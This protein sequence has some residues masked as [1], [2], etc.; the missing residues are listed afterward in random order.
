MKNYIYI[1][2]EGG[3]GLSLRVG[4]EKTLVEIIRAMS[5]CGKLDV[6][7]SPL[8][9]GLTLLRHNEKLDTVQ[10]APD[11]PARGK[12]V[13]LGRLDVFEEGDF[14]PQPM[15][16]YPDGVILSGHVFTADN[17]EGLYLTAIIPQDKIFYA[18]F[19][20]KSKDEEVLSF[21]RDESPFNGP[22]CGA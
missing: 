22:G 3:T 12:G 14:F 4:D 1:R 20:M 15:T 11:V 5:Q 13:L 2:D 16:V 6:I 19:V 7:A 9:G 8:F 21:V 18:H 17:P 10:L